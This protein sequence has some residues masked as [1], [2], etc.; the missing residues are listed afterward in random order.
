MAGVWV[1]TLRQSATSVLWTIL[2]LCCLGAFVAI[3]L[4]VLFR[5]G[6]LWR[7][8]TALLVAALVLAVAIAFLDRFG[9]GGYAP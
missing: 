5:W 1:L 4:G 7:F 6:N 2:V 8:A 9:F 3:V